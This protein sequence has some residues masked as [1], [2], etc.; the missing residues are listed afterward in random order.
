MKNFEYEHYT[1]LLR[2]P[3]GKIT[4]EIKAKNRES[5]IKQI[6]TLVKKSN[7][8]QNL[9]ESIFN[10]IT[11][12]LEVFWETLTLDHVGYNRLF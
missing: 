12:I 1:I 5:A 9:S 10:R 6:N 4:Y 7:S 11:P 8:E 3:T 2:E